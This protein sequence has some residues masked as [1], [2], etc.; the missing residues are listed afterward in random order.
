MERWRRFVLAGMFLVTGA[1]QAN[2]I[3]ARLEF[4]IEAQP[5]SRAILELSR[6]SN[7]DI[8][9]PSQLIDGKRSQ[10]VRGAMTALEALNSLLTGSGLQA[11]KVSQ[12]SLA[13]VRVVG[14]G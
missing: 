4:L 6:Q 7:T 5:L 3:D 12:T 9:A 13:I 11:V 1:A 2:E 8:L 10:G 14:K